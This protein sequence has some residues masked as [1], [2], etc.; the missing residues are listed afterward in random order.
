MTKPMTPEQ[1]KQIKGTTPINTR[2]ENDN[3]ME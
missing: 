3:G 1:F 2:K